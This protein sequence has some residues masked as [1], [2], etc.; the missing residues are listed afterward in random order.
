MTTETE[1]NQQIDLEFKKWNDAVYEG[2]K[3]PNDIMEIFKK[4]IFRLAPA[5]HRIPADVIKKLAKTKVEDLTNME[6]AL[7]LNQISAVPLSGLYKDLFEALAKTAKIETIKMSYNLMVK[8]LNEVMEEK[9]QRLLK[10]SG[11]E[12]NKQPNKLFTA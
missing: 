3:L 9:R 4:A 1:I 10:L 2:D 11:V 12:N 8:N 7:V 5:S 6:V